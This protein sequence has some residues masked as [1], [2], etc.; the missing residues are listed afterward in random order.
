M[1]YLLLIDPLYFQTYCSS[2]SLTPYFGPVKPYV[3]CPGRHKLDSDVWGRCFKVRNIG[4]S[5]LQGVKELKVHYQ[6]NVFSRDHKGC[7]GEREE[8]GEGVVR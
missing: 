2:S 4:N 8:M 1:Q 5:Y 6:K 7:F 3:F